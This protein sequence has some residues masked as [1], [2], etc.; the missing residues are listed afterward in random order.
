MAKEKYNTILTH[1]DRMTPSVWN[2][3]FE[4]QDKPR[5]DFIPGQ[6]VMVEVPKEGEKPVK[7]PYSIASPPHFK[8]KIELTIKRVEGGYVS[9]W[10]FRLHVGDKVEF[11]GPMGVFRLKEP[12][13][14]HLLFVAT[15]SGIAPLRA[16]IHHQLQHGDQRSMSLVFG[17]RYED[18]ILFHQE[19]LDLAKKY[20]NFEYLPVISRPKAWTGAKGYVQDIIRQKFPSPQD[21]AVYICGLVPMVND[22]KATL[23]EIGYP[24]EA[25]HFEKWT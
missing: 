19:F 23:E 10:F 18:E 22:L 7:K 25:I 6:F 9:N 12:L 5:F 21:K 4:F 1:I 13:P 3:H 11:E 17:N 8:N 20:P 2:F 24:K 14:P 15:G 16:Q